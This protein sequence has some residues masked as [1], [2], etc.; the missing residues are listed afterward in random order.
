MDSSKQRY[1]KVE[2]PCRN[3]N[4]LGLTVI[5][6]PRDGREK[7]VLS[8]FSAGSVG[9]IILIDTETGEGESIKLPGDSGA[10]AVLNLNNEK[11]LLGTCPEYG[12]LHCLDLKTRTWAE[13]LRDPNEKYI[14]KLALGSDGKAY[15]G[16]W[17]GCVLLRYD[18]EKHVLD[19]LGS[20]TG[21]P[22]NMYSRPVYGGLP[23]YILV[24]GGYD[25][26]FL[27]AWDI[28]KESFRIIAE[29]ES[30]LAPT[31]REIN[32]E[33]ICVTTGEEMSFYNPRTFELMDDPSLKDKVKPWEGLKLKDGRVFCLRGQEYYYKNTDGSMSG[34]TS[35]PTPAPPTQIHTITSDSNGVI[36]G[37]CGFGQTIFK[38][39]S[40]KN[41]YWNSSNVCN[42]GGEV[43]GMV[44]EDGRLFMTA[45]VGGDHMVFEPEAKWDQLNNVNPKT[46]KTMHPKLVRPLA[47]SIKGPD[48]GIWT[49][50]AADY[51]VYGGGLTRIDTSSMEVE[52]WYDPVP[53]QQINSITADGK[54]L[55]FTTSGGGNG[56]P[57]RKIECHFCVWSCK[58]EILYD[59]VFDKDTA[60]NCT[61]TA[62]GKVLVAAGKDILI[63][64]PSTM[65]FC[66]TIEV[67]ERCGCMLR[68]D[69]STVLA[70]CEKN[71]YRIDAEK[72]SFEHVL[73][74]PGHVGTAAV[75]PGGEVYFSCKTVLY[76]LG[77]G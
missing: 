72:G 70:F 28:E 32:E 59:H 58:G 11:L 60:L 18:P 75:T 14:W 77:N 37:S 54:Y 7:V 67:G 52:Y 12:Y 61:Q 20:I 76:R 47:R 30:N 1:I 69:D 24:S 15:G 56:L 53:E 10:W 29:S 64:D 46:I 17:P 65:E 23:G 71:L 40:V 22:K 49:G 55:Y 26:P 31:V 5:D 8:N 44:F 36:W 3:F 27:A 48:N 9:N 38:Y 34:L 25:R 63:F 6:D 66:G 74:L 13:P 41:S 42:H 45:Y 50:W 73:A 68:I 19:N 21:N 4:I 39:D 33:F 51:G 2:E 35:I 16:T 43:Y 62:G 57:D